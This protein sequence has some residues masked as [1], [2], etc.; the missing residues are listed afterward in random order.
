MDKT[1]VYRKPMGKSLFEKEFYSR[2]PLP[3]GQS[4]G[5]TFLSGGF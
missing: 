4:F 1:T 2:S 3:N 5:T